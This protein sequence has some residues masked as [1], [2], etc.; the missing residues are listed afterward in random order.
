M[1]FKQE[2][3]DMESDQRTEKIKQEFSR[4]IR[5]LS[6]S[7][8]YLDVCEEACGYRLPLF[9]M[10]DKEQLDYL[11]NAVPIASTDTVLDLGCGDG[12]LL[13][14]L[15][16]KYGCRGIGIDLLDSGLVPFGKDIQYICGSFEHLKDYGLSPTVTL[17]IDSMYFCAGTDKTVE[18]LGSRAG[19]RL[20]LYWS[21]YLLDEA[22]DR[23]CLNSG[24]TALACS[25]R[26]AGIA[27]RAVDFSKNEH[28]L[29]IALEQALRERRQAFEAEGRL[30]LYRQKLDETLYG[31]ELYEKRMASRYL[32]IADQ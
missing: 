15:A 18:Q 21:Q 3:A 7:P 22:A 30:D 8:A 13:R 20:Y 23:D 5:G 9:N 10:M 12:S 6:N 17:S 26:K 11:L 29:Y 1:K 24:R 28:R 25:L 32:Y 2:F 16:A 14:L 27:Y 4:K 19:N 31:I